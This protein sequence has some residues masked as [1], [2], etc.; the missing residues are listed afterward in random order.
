M[1][2]ILTHTPQ[3]NLFFHLMNLAL[4]S[5]GKGAW[6]LAIILHLNNPQWMCYGVNILRFQRNPNSHGCG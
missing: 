5:L 1:Y 6:Q 3:D 4:V 2:P